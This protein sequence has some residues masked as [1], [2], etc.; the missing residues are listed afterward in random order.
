[1]PGKD[2]S[3]GYLSRHE[4]LLTQRSCQNI[5]GV[6]AQTTEEYFDRLV[7]SVEDVPPQNILNYDETNLCDDTGRRNCIFKR[8]TKY[9]DRILNSTKSAVSIIFA[10]TAVGELLPPYDVYKADDFMINGPPGTRYNRTKSGWFDGSTFME[11][12]QTIVL[13]WGKKLQRPKVII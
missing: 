3:Y 5:K 13:P 6:R 9:H 8:G 4:D 10:A 12:F 1:M 7:I 11:W 2:W